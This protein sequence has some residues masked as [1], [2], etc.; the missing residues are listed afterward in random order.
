MDKIVICDAGPLIALAKINQLDLLYIIFKYVFISDTV[1]DECL[2]NEELPG[3]KIIKTA[4][5][6]HFIHVKTPQPNICIEREIAIL[7][8]G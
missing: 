5:E 1:R 4:I 6:N 7:D 2:Y 3:A 8:L